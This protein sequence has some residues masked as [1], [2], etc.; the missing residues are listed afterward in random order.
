MII[1]LY[2]GEIKAVVVNIDVGK[3][4]KIAKGDRFVQLV[5]IPKMDMTVEHVQVINHSSNIIF[6][7]CNLTRTC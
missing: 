4:I 7:R 1:L 3:K 5:P 2:R 6:N